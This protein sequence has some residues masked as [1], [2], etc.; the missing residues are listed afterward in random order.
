MKVAAFGR[1]WMLSGYKNLINIALLGLLSTC[2]FTGCQPFSKFGQS[3]KKMGYPEKAFEGYRDF[4]WAQ[5]AFNL[6]YGNCDIAHSEDFREGFLEGYCEMCE[7]GNGHTPALPPQEYWSERFQS[8]QG[9]KSVESWFRGY[10]EGVRAAKQDGVSQFRNV[11]MSNEMKMAL[12]LSKKQNNSTVTSEDIENNNPSPVP[13]PQSSPGSYAPPFPAT[14]AN[15]NPSASEF[16]YHSNQFQEQQS[17]PGGY[18]PPIVGASNLPLPANV[19]PAS[20]Q[21]KHQN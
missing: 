4:V 7:G 19:Q 17:V 13:F 6:R 10:P 5:R 1:H 2:L 20:W 9:K 18:V 15:L 8:Q 14:P 3:F 21:S 11:Y 16:D 12:K